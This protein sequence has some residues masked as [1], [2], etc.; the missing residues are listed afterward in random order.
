MNK[1]NYNIDEEIAILEKYELSPT[2]LFIIKSIILMQE[3]YEENY[4][5]RFLHLPEKIRGDFRH[6]LISLQERGF[7]LKEYK[8][9]NKGEEFNP[10]E[11]PINKLL[12]KTIYKSSFDLGQELFETYPLFGNIQ[13]SIVSLRGIS[14]KFDSLEDFYRFYGKTIKWNP[15]VHQHILSLINWEK[16]NNIGFINFSLSTFVI[17]HKW[18]ELE[19]LKDGSLTN[20][21]FNNIVSL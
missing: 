16:D 18:E 3:G 1:Y 17:E 5:I 2:E 13:G 7:I 20:I 15:E 8:I 11:I 10:L 6:H 9:P 19:A 12:F 21:N 4:L 14:K